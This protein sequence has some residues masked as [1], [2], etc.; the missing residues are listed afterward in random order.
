MTCVQGNSVHLKLQPSTFAY[1]GL[2]KY[3]CTKVIWDYLVYVLQFV[4]HFGFNMMDVYDNENVRV[5]EFE[6]FYRCLFLFVPN[7]SLIFK[8]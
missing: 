4:C 5:H 3:S 6:N 1:T 8:N 7:M 2:L